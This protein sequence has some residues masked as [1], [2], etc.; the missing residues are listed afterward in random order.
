LQLR[1]WPAW[2]AVAW[3]VGVSWVAIDAQKPPQGLAAD[4]PPEAFSAARAQAH[5]E[6]IA[7]VPHPMGSAESERIRAV[8]LEKL[9]E[10][11][12]E[13]QI[14][15]PRR[16]DSPV[17]NVVGRRKGRGPEGKK[18]LMLSAHYDSVRSS[19]GASDDASGV[20]VILETV[21]ATG[22][23]PGLDRDLIVLFTDGEEQGCQGAWLFVDEHP[24][25]KQVGVVLNFDARGNSGPSVMF[26]TSDGNGWLIREYAQAAR[27]P[28]A[29]SVSMDVYRILPNYSDLTVFKLA[30]MGGL[31]FGFGGGVAYYH[32]ADDTPENLDDDTLQH[33][34]DNALATTLRLGRL[35]LDGTKSTDVVYTSILNRFVVWYSQAWVRPLA[36]AAA[37][38]FVVVTLAGVRAAQMRIV[39]LAVGAFVLFASM[40]ASLVAVGFVALAGTCS[41]LLLDLSNRTQIAWEKYDVPIMTGFAVLTAA[42]TLAVARWAG[43]RHSL[44]ALG[45]GAF[46]WWLALTFATAVWVPGASYLFLW[47]TLAGVAGLGVSSRSR[48]GS[49]VGWTATVVSSLPTLL[50]LPPMIRATFDGLSLRMTAPIMILVVLFVGTMLPVLGPLVASEPRHWK[51]STGAG[52]RDPSAESA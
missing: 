14:Q 15:A 35:D 31:N 17:R 32:S 51:A 49:A 20:A 13:V 6:A 36:A 5:V 25:A 10:L 12:L 2:L 41:S 27:S 1:H 21:R 46:S 4:A 48:P 18:N 8:L 44:V 43:R 39:D 22:A 3:A 34:G 42:I 45:L 9:K 24:W 16:G 28:L 38:L 19:P 23:A 30:G 33:Q 52:E 7:R 11:G 26:E 37:L 50:L 40:C 29:T 47:P